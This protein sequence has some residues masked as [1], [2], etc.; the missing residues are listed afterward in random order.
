MVHI[1]PQYLLSGWGWSLSHH[2]YVPAVINFIVSKPHLGL[3]FAAV[4]FSEQMIT[5]R[6]VQGDLV[7]A[8]K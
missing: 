2:N 8:S 4:R 3:C 5:H 6:G 7:F 1:V